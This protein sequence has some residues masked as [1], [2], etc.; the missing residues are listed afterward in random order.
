MRL[1]SPKL[2]CKFEMP[3]AKPS[4]ERLYIGWTD[5]LPTLSTGGP[6]A[7]SDTLLNNEIG[8]IL[9]LKTTDST[10][11]I[12]HNNASASASVIDTGKA[13]DINI[14][15]VAVWAS[16]LG[17]GANNKWRVQ[18]DGLDPIE[19]ND[20]QIPAASNTIYPVVAAWKNSGTFFR[21]RGWQVESI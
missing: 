10:Y 11:K 5:T 3:A 2:V 12:Y 17:I 8:I 6:G 19:I 13:S 15:T 9:G 20:S 18:L 4:S 1:R 14:H 21:L 16:E 7:F